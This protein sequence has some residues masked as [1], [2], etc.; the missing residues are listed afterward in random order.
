MLEYYSKNSVDFLDESDNGGEYRINFNGAK[1]K[2]LKNIRERIYNVRNALVHNKN[3]YKY[4]TYNP[5]DNENTLM[6]EILLIKILAIEV[7]VN[8]S[9]KIN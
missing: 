4:K 5:Y 8:T 6:K 9:E 3:N 7:I 1:N 2:T